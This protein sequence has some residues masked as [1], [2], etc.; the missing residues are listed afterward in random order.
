MPISLTTRTCRHQHINP[1]AN[2]KVQHSSIIPWK[3]DWQ[4]DSSATTAVIIRAA[5]ALTLMDYTG[6]DDVA[7]GLTVSGRTVPIPGID[8]MAGPTINTVPLRICLA[9]PGASIGEFLTEVHDQAVNMIEYEQTGLH[10]IRRLGDN[11]REACEFQNILI[12]QGDIESQSTIFGSPLEAQEQAGFYVNPLTIECFIKGDGVQVD[13]HFDNS[14]IAEE[15]VHHVLSHFEHLL[16]QLV[17]QSPDTTL[18]DIRSLSSKDHE[19]IT[20][21]NKDCTETI[22]EY[23]HEVVQKQ[24]ELYPEHLAVHGWDASFTYQQLDE[25]SDKLA[26]LSCGLWH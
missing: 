25:L 21:W 6:D 8:R 20:Q 18:R 22:N 7:F 24:A 11:L 17:I 19:V 26:C 10:E 5:W 13:A 1:R 3:K 14:I 4:K 23:V 9:E 2:R 12:V 15:Q 16:A